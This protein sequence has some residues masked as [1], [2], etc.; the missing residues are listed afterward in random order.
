MEW[1]DYFCVEHR[2]E[3]AVHLEKVERVSGISSEDFIANFLKPGKPVILT[4]FVHKDSP[5]VHRWSYACVK[6]IASNQIISVF[7]NEEESRDLV[8]SASVAKLKFA[9][10]IYLIQREPTDLINFLYNLLKLKPQL[11]KV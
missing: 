2:K 8:A 1:I 10:Y 4:D 7:G 5:G 3:K 9:E 11:S 6:A